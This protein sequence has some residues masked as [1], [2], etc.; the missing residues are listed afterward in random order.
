MGKFSGKSFRRGPSQHGE[1]CGYLLELISA[2]SLIRRRHLS[3]HFLISVLGTILYKR[4]RS[5]VTERAF[6]IMCSDSFCNRKLKM[7]S[8][9]KN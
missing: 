9:E 1:Q 3:D 4:I 2:K 7:G 8:W 5:P 6:A